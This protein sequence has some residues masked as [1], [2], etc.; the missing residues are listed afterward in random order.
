MVLTRF[1]SRQIHPCDVTSCHH[2]LD[3]VLANDT[4]VTIQ[5]QPPPDSSRV[6]PIV[7]IPLSR[8]TIISVCALRAV[9]R[10]A[11]PAIM[12]VFYE[13]AQHGTFEYHRVASTNRSGLTAAFPSL[14][15]KTASPSLQSLPRTCCAFA[16]ELAHQPIH[17]MLQRARGHPLA[18]IVATL[19]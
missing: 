18:S 4:S 17:S 19:S 14:T 6:V 12:C 16:D 2:V 15:S 8:S 13:G 5:K 10:H 7:S 1:R 11:N 9:H 3:D